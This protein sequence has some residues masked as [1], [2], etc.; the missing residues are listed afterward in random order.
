MAWLCVKP[1]QTTPF[2]A[3]AMSIAPSPASSIEP[4]DAKYNRVLIKVSG[5]ALMGERSY[6][7]DPETVTRVCRDIKE[8]VDMGVQ[9][10]LV[11]GG[12]NIYRG[13]QAAAHGMERAS[14]DYVGMLATV[15]NALALQNA[16]EQLGV[17]TRVLSA[18]QMMEVCE[19][20]IRR[21]A[22]RHMQQGRVVI[23]AAGTG[24]PFFTTDTTASLRA[25]ETGCSVMIKGTQVEG[26]YDAD[27]R[28]V[29]DAKRYD[30][31]TYHEVLA[32]D[33]K[34]MDASAISLARENNLPIIVC[35][36]KEPGAFARVLRGEGAF[37]TIRN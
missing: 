19:P 28:K 33:L 29:P 17:E 6:G 7:Q 16:L 25:I 37:T 10:C 12:G 15:L 30:T 24:N 4:S 35:S 5:E 2:E 8:V 3:S 34:V 11:T 22:I 32:R 26:I 21:R 20:Y 18:I 31:I 36:I 1:E 14:A 23:C 9:V 13:V 27:P